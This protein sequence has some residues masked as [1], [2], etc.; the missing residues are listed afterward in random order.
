MA[1]SN[2]QYQ[3]LMREYDRRQ[4]S[5]L[6]R[7]QEHIQE[8][9][10]TQPVIQELDEEISRVSL[11]S[12]RAALLKQPEEKDRLKEK[13]QDLRE[14][15]TLLLQ[16]AGYPPDYM[17]MQ[18]TCPLC[19]DTGYIGQE[20]CRCFKKLEAALYL[21][22]S[23]LKEVLSEENFSRYTESFYDNTYLL[24]AYR[25][26]VQAHMHQVYLECV[27]YTREF[28]EKGGN[29]LL[30]G[31]AGTG[32]TFFTHCI[33]AELLRQGFGVYYL[34]A[35][36]LTGIV[37]GKR[38]WNREPEQYGEA[39]DRIFSCELLL[40]DDLG[41]EWN[42]TLTNSEL[43]ACLNERLRSGKSCVISTNLDLK[44]LSERYSERILSRMI[45]YYRI[46][47]FVGTDIR[48]LKKGLQG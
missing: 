1:L 14:Q 39:Y 43:F 38:S 40:I 45:G 4:E 19:S 35:T 13:L 37:S 32:K 22:Q 30:T 46:L 36:E 3:N 33:A 41:T 34:T 10:K 29:L 24:P 7:K 27:R 5:A 28:A 47:E 18:Y 44:G 48:M 26:T 20:K 25:Q 17:E 8:V 15:K 16:K 23:G 12:A 2:S 9:Y 11:Q 21:E 31:G 6:R 42:N